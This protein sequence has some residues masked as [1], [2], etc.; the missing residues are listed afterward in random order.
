[1]THNLNNNFDYIVFNTMLIKSILIITV[2]IL[3]LC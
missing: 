1:M 3:V 2:Y